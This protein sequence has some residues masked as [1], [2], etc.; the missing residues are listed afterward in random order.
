MTQ[1][2][3]RSSIISPQPTKLGP[4]TE[5]RPL[6]PLCITPVLDSTKLQP[7]CFT[8]GS[9][10]ANGR[11]TGKMW[12]CAAIMRV[13]ANS[14]PFAIKLPLPRIV[15]FQA[16]PVAGTGSSLLFRSRGDVYGT[17]K[18]PTDQIFGFINLPVAARTFLLY[19]RSRRWPFHSTKDNG[20]I[21]RSPNRQPRRRTSR[22]N[23]KRTGCGSA[24]SDAIREWG[25]QENL[26][27]RLS[28]S[29]GVDAALAHVRLN[30]GR[31][32]STQSSVTH[33]STVMTS[34]GCK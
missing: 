13:S 10:A 14:M 20:R 16:W 9:P 28:A 3:P 30:A 27:N 4:K 18:W 15:A 29:G 21:R 31:A 24:L 33:C 2:S 1:A 6:A 26:E 19:L 12:K 22:F 25:F 5:P 11:G 7:V 23:A 8:I 34:G 17:V 32:G